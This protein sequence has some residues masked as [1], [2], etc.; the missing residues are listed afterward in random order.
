[1]PQSGQENDASPERALEAACRVAEK[2]GQVE[3]QKQTSPMRTLVAIPLEAG[4]IESRTLGLCFGS[5]INADKVN[6]VVEMIRTQIQVQQ[7]QQQISN[8]DRVVT[9]TSAIIQ[10]VE[11]ILAS[12]TIA[13][14]GQRWM[15]QIRASLPECRLALGICRRDAKHIRL[16]AISDAP[17]VDRHAAKTKALQGIMNHVLK[18][19]EE[20]AWTQSSGQ[21]PL[22]AIADLAEIPGIQLGQILG[23]PLK[24]IGDRI[25][26]VLMILSS[27]PAARWDADV[28]FIRASAPSIAAALACVDRGAHGVLHRLRQ[29]LGRLATARRRWVSSAALAAAAIG[30]G[31]PVTHRITA[32]SRVEP[33]HRRF[34]AAPFD[35]KLQRSFAKPGDVVRQGN[36]LAKLD[37]HEIRWKRASV[38]AEYN[39]AKKKRDAA[40][41]A[42]NYSEQQI[43]Q[44]EMEQHDIELQLLDDRIANL[45]I[46]SPIPG[47]ITSGDLARVEG[48][49]LTQGQSM[50]E[51]APLER[52]I[53]ELEIQDHEIAYVELGQLA[54]LHIDAYPGQVW[55]GRIQRVRPRAEIRDNVNVFIAEIELDNADLRLRPG[56]KGSVEVLGRTRPYGW[57]LMHEPF[58][59]FQRLLS[60]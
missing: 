54:R 17:G 16:V 42:R 47:V 5:H 13:Q 50:F 36:V 29:K 44:L 11:E 2:N 58:E 26:G 34:V 7:L 37:D 3:V 12:E 28:R 4:S 41:A 19:G 59:Y 25:V 49:P 21:T 27:D 43:A 53:A 9:E 15:V 45:D 57:I 52:M 20:I 30:F 18:V 55:S 24:D 6:G 35:G 22:P 60:W 14:A 51:V 40:Q 39:Q 38:L 31:M 1:L 23:I 8:L 33:V 46:T 56:M 32:T 10:L 48:A